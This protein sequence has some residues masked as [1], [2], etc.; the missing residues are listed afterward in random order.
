MLTFPAGYGS[1]SHHH[2][3][4]ALEAC[5]EAFPGAL[6]E[7]ASDSGRDRAPQL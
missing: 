6:K 5:H 1:G 3:Q 2:V 7:N 4:H